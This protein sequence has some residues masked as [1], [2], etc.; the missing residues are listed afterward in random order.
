MSITGRSH[1]IRVKDLAAEIGLSRTTIWRE[2]RAGRLPK[3]VALSRRC[4]GWRSEDVDAWKSARPVP[5]Q[6]N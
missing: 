6:H 1:L 5:D 3:P 4:V 2:V